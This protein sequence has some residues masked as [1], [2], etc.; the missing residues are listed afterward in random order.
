MG[1]GLKEKSVHEEYLKQKCQN[2]NERERNVILMID[3][4][5][6]AN[7]MA[8][9]EGKLEGSASNSSLTEAS[10]AQ[11]FMISSIL[12]K[13]KDV[14]AIIPMKNMNAN[15]L[16]G[17]LLKV[18]KML[19]TTGYS[20]ICV[21]SDNNRV[22]RNAF[23]MLCGDKLQP[24]IQNPFNVT[25]K[26]FFLFDS[27]HLVKCIRNNWLTQKDA[28]KTF[29]FPSTENKQN[30]LRASF[31]LL[32]R[33]FHEEK[34]NLVKLAPSLNLKALYPTSTEKQ[35]VSLMLRIFNQTNVV[36]LEHF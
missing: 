36:A 6:V 18:L 1:S 19:H 25:E 3:E 2:M 8:Y 32:R 23:T 4:I 7:K 29:L 30:M 20:V 28:E 9:K 26:I 31:S 15:M 14:V 16:H 10:T 17:M 24:F 21:I 12:S 5:H 11:V 33:L 34:S 13:Y 22:N 35:N 27:V